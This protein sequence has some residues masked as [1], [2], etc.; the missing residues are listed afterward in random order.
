MFMIDSRKMR[1]LEK[2][3]LRKPTNR[4]REVLLLLALA[5]GLRIT[6]VRNLH[7]PARE[8][9][10]T[11]VA[12]AIEYC[13]Q[14]RATVGLDASRLCT[15]RRPVV[16][17]GRIIAISGTVRG[18]ISMKASDVRVLPALEPGDSYVD[19]NF[20]LVETVLADDGGV[21]TTIDH[22]SSQSVNGKDKWTVNTLG[23]SVP[24]DHAA[25]LEWSVSYAASRDI[26]LVYERDH[27]AAESYAA[28]RSTGDSPASSALK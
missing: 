19:P 12:A 24:L 10:F 15:K 17:V 3:L 28:A 20:L 23:Q 26:P 9:S 7:R 8:R 25:A 18:L 1:D 2:R 11:A 6:V 4:R 27:T 14:M 22:V 16:T 21:V 13:K 5:L